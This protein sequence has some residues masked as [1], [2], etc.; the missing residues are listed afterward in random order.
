MTRSRFASL[1]S[2]VPLLAGLIGS[3]AAN[4]AFPPPPVRQMQGIPDGVFNNLAE[5]VCRGCHNQNPPAGIPVNPMYLPNRHHL[6]VGM[7][8]PTGSDVPFPDSDG[9][10]VADTT[11]ACLNCHALEWDPVTFSYVLA[12]NFRNCMNCHIQNA[13]ATVH[14]RTT[15]A[16]N[17]DCK[18]CHGGLINNP[19]DGHY[20][21]TYQPS[22]VTPWP[23]GKPNGDTNIT[24]SAGT[25]PGNCNFCHNTANG[26]AG[27]PGTN[28]EATWI[29]FDGGAPFYVAVYQNP[30]THH[31]TGLQIIDPSRCS[32]CHDPTA[33]T[34]A[35]IRQCESCHGVQSLHNI[36]ADT[37]G[38]GVKPGQEDAGWS[39]TGANADCWG[40]HGNNGVIMAA[41]YGGPG[42]PALQG[43]STSTV[44]AG[45]NSVITVEGLNFT[46]YVQNPLTGAFDIYLTSNI[47]L[48]D[49]TGATFTFTPS[50]ITETSATFTVPSTQAAGAYQLA[51]VKGPSASNPYD[52]SITPPASISSATCSKGKKTVTIAGAGFGQYLNA[53]DSSTSV[54]MNGVKGTVQSWTDTDV[55]ARFPSCP[56]GTLTVTVNTVFDSASATATKVR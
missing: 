32:W 15:F 20:V 3:G 12:Q 27:A 16:A 23:S 51:V 44:E 55:K 42:I 6:K 25:H 14:H 9:N 33:P 50:A 39:H 53:S 10:G 43:L 22:L 36:T 13:E 1:I 28:L 24:S 38:D 48:T 11:Y 5:P 26:A 54:T 4:A 46:N 8:I 47:V 18:A 7:T 45:G 52:F 30:E 29:R 37:N 2:A 21:P 34:G 41:P 19:L 56:N 35:A 49:S 31:S 40:C 17:R